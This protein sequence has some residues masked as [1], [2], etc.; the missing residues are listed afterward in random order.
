MCEIFSKNTEENIIG[1]TE[2]YKE[3]HRHPTAHFLQEST[4]YPGRRKNI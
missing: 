2:E 1:I 3:A 4:W